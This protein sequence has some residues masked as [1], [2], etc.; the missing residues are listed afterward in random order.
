MYSNQEKLDCFVKVITPENVEFEYV[1][2]GPFQRFPAFVIDFFIRAAVV[3][4]VWFVLSASSIIA[5][6]GFFIGLVITILLF[7]LLSWFYGVY[8]ETR[9]NGQ[10]PGKMLIR[11]RVISVDGRPINGMQAALRNFLRF[12]DLLPIATTP[13]F[14]VGMG[15]MV[16]NKRFQRIGDLAAGTMVVVDRGQRS[17]WDLQPDDTRAFGLAELIPPTFVPS[18][19]LSQAVGLYMENRQ[20]LP[21]TRRTDVAKYVALPLIRKFELLP[22]T[23]YDLLMCA[24]YVKI[25]MSENQQLVG[26]D[27]MRRNMRQQPAQQPMF[28][29]SVL[30]NMAQPAAVQLY[31]PVLGN[32]VP[33]ITND[34]AQTMVLEP[35]AEPSPPPL[36]PSQP[37]LENPNSSERG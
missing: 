16:I 25:F 26:R 24:L 37:E 9:F 35:L 21:P 32:P 19:S 3:F 1:L 6:V 7:F 23:S 18:R 11:L 28:Y 17:P 29:P 4:G 15:C 8:F 34:P 27:Q 31:P 22:D 36:P 10:T 33:P 20:R 2:A 14:F 30:P 5:P 12:A 13:T